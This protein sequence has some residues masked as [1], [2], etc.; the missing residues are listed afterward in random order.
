MKPQRDRCQELQR[1]DLSP[2][3]RRQESPSPPQTEP[4][5]SITHLQ[6]S[7][8][9]QRGT[10]DPKQHPLRGTGLLYVGVATLSGLCPSSGTSS[11]GESVS[12]SDMEPSALPSIVQLGKPFFLLFFRHFRGKVLPSYKNY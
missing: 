12:G 7:L 3:Q 1:A 10:Q 2:E 6:L 9:D 8:L 11:Q 4:L 5:W